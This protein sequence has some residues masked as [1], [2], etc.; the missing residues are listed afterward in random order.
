ML[1]MHAKAF[2]RIQT[3]CKAAQHNQVAPP[4]LESVRHI[5]KYNP[6][7]RMSIIKYIDELTID[8][9]IHACGD[10]LS[11]A[12]NYVDRYI[13]SS[14]QS[15]RESTREFEERRIR[16]LHEEFAIKIGSECSQKI[17]KFCR[18]PAYEM[19]YIL[20]KRCG[21][22]WENIQ[23]IVS[24]CFAIASKFVEPIRCPRLREL[25]RVHNFENSVQDFEKMETSI[26][27]SLNWKINVVLPNHF[28]KDICKVCDFLPTNAH[29]NR[30][31]EITNAI[32]HICD[33][34]KYSPLILACTVFLML[35]TDFQE[36]QLYDKNMPILLDVCKQYEQYSEMNDDLRTKET[37]KTKKTKKT[38]NPLLSCKEDLKDVFHV[39][40]Q[41]N[42]YKECRNHDVT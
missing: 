22:F 10:I 9:Q 19:D 17:L 39:I 36:T 8:F 15:I 31:D 41:R 40:S 28:F 16:W 14:I 7:N 13:I 12:A 11:L 42:Q 20:R 26:L 30:F 35:W 4:Y 21:V 37:K 32:P 5:C 27:E 2:D 23:L 3:I 34:M 18:R 33:S 1:E 29:I 38:K 6:T 25:E 24:T